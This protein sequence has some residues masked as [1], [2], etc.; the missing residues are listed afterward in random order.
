[1]FIWLDETGWDKHNAVRQYGYALRGLTPRCTSIAA[2]IGW[3]R[4]CI[5]N[6]GKCE[7]SSDH[8]W[9]SRCIGEVSSY[10]THWRKCL[11]RLN[12]GY[13]HTTL[14]FRPHRIL[15]YLLLWQTAQWARTTVYH[16]SK[17]LDI[18][19]V[20]TPTGPWHTV[21]FFVFCQ[22]CTSPT[23]P[24]PCIQYNHVANNNFVY[25]IQC[26]TNIIVSQTCCWCLGFINFS[27][28]RM[29]SFCSITSH[30]LSAPLSNRYRSSLSCWMYLLLIS[31]SQLDGVED[32]DLFGELNA[33]ALDDVIS[34][35]AFESAVVWFGFVLP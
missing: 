18:C 24:L 13:N 19:K 31:I 20:V 21:G 30:L 35:S 26:H 16:T 33:D 25:T 11:Q 15:V 34:F 32:I 7:R 14:S 17:I 2:I 6:R 8:Y 27:C 5:H 23:L 3:N 29:G 10:L 1:M 28:W 12:T 4:R 22:I 9:K